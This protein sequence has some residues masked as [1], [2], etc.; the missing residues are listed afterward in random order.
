[1]IGIVTSMVCVT[2]LRISAATN[3]SNPW[4][5]NDTRGSTSSTMSKQPTDLVENGI[6]NVALRLVDRLR[7]LDEV[8]HLDLRLDVLLNRAFGPQPR[9]APEVSK[10]CREVG[11]IGLAHGKVVH[12]KFFAPWATIQR[13]MYRPMPPRP[14]ARTYVTS[15]RSFT[16]SLIRGTTYKLVNP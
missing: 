5:V 13:A 10:W 4:L 2:Q 1:M 6:Q 7:R 11:F 15:A 14:P 3:E 16:T 9:H 12:A 8:A